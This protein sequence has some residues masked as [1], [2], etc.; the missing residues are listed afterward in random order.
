MNLDYDDELIRGLAAEDPAA[1]LEDGDA[2]VV[3]A[4]IESGRVEP[5]RSPRSPRSPRRSATAVVAGL[6]VAAALAVALLIL[7]PAGSPVG[8]G[9]ESALAIERQADEIV[10]RIEDPTAS[11]EQMNAELEEAGIDGVRVLSLPGPDEDV[12]TWAGVAEFGLTC[13]GHLPSYGG[14]VNIPPVKPYTSGPADNR[15]MIDLNFPNAYGPGAPP[16]REVAVGRNVVG[17]PYSGAVARI[18][19]RTIDYP[20]NSAKVLVPIKPDDGSISNEIGVEQLRSLGGEFATIANELEQP[21][22]CED[23]GMKPLPRPRH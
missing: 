14:D 20:Y 2:D 12:G 5:P 7:L 16:P 13:K 19:A 11:D 23:L 21:A 1:S 4:R 22:S 18:D 9:T 3:R 10:L 15:D 8:G 6:G 17:T